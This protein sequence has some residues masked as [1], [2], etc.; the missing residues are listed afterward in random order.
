MSI[1]AAFITWLRISFVSD[2]FDLV[3]ERLAPR[4]TSQHG[5][6]CREEAP[7][8]IHIYTV[9]HN[10]PRDSNTIV[11]LKSFVGSLACT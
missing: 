10:Y 5:L 2:F 8:G 3:K 11:C 6:A 9:V 1:E 7:S 4:V